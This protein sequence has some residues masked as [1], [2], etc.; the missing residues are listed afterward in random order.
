MK[1]YNK[2]KAN[3]KHKQLDEKV[4]EESDEDEDKIALGFEMLVLENQVIEK[5]KN[6]FAQLYM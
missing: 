3:L 4:R 1:Q 2:E 6:E 5:N